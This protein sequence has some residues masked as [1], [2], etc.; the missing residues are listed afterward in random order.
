MGY[1]LHMLGRCVSQFG[2][3]GS[4]YYR[5]NFNFVE[6]LSSSGLVSGEWPLDKQNKA[7]A[8]YTFGVGH[9]VPPSG[10]KGDK[11]NQGS[12][13]VDHGIGQGITILAPSDK[14]WDEY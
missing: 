8:P 3:S 13:G 7:R 4:Y 9:V 10:D 12:Q 6:L 2:S 14:A 1:S 11:E 5:R